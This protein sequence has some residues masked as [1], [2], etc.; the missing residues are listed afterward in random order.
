MGRLAERIYAGALM[1]V[2]AGRSSGD[3]WRG[4]KLESH[5]LRS[6]RRGKRGGRR[7]AVLLYVSVCPKIDAAGFGKTF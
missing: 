7:G 1:L 3:T 6:V 5:G 2:D 4:R